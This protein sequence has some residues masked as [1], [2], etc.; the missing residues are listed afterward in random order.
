MIDLRHLK[1]GLFNSGSLNTGQDEFTVAMDELNPD[2]MAINETWLRAGE[3]DKAPKLPG[4]R[5]LYLPRP[6]HIKKGR[7]GG[8]GF[9]VRKG[10]NAR[11]CPHPDVPT[12]EQM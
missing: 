8:V 1:V 11:I 5:M 9:Y 2:I 4:Y 7:G 3:D 12:V 6:K 10:I